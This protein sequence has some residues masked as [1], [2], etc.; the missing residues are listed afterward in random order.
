MVKYCAAVSGQNDGLSKKHDPLS[1]MPEK[2]SH[3]RMAMALKHQRHSDLGTCSE[4]GAAYTSSK[5]TL[6][7]MTQDK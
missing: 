6:D 1:T 5:R 2:V 3:T 7:Q 4:S